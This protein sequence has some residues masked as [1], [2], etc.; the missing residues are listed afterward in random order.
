MNES[1]AIMICEKLLMDCGFPGEVKC[2]TLR[3]GDSI[4]YHI[5]S[6]DR[7][8]KSLSSWTHAIVQFLELLK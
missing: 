2:Y 6:L 3:A 7:Q 5:H 1:D 8:S 4:I